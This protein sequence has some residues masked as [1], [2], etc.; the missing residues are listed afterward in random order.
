MS[1]RP[2]KGGPIIRS[3]MEEGGKG[4][5]FFFLFRKGAKAKRHI[6]GPYFKN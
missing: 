3:M 5:R 4:N 1:S 2:T 6:T